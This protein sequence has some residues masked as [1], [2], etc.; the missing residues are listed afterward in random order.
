MGGLECFVVRDGVAGRNIVQQY[1]TGT[2]LYLKRPLRDPAHSIPGFELSIEMPSIKA[3]LADVEYAMITTLASENTTEHVVLP[4]GAA[5]MVARHGGR[6]SGDVVVDDHEQ[7]GG[8]AVGGGGGIQ[9]THTQLGGGGDDD[10]TQQAVTTAGVSVGGEALELGPGFIGSTDTIAV[11]V[12][13]NIGQVCVCMVCM[14]GVYVWC[15][16]MVC[17]YGVYC[18]HTQNIHNTTHKNK[19]A[20]HKTTHRLVSSY[21]APPPPIPPPS[22]LPALP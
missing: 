8:A 11:R 18:H 7:G 2:Q 5:W 15:V 9:E 4:A 3:C 22:P 19:N 14:Y 1:D 6:T 16:C 21:S 13:V 17:T 20:L 12:A 10:T